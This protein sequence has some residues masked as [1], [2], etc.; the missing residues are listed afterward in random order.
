MEKS[1]EDLLKEELKNYNWFYSLSNNNKEW[2]EGFNK[3]I[4]IEKMIE[5]NPKLKE[6]YDEEKR[7]KFV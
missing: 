3:T 1:Q 7:K 5:K 6:I 2:L 4:K